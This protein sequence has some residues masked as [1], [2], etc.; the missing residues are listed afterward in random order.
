MAVTPFCIWTLTRLGTYSSRSFIELIEFVTTAKWSDVSP[1]SVCILAN[2]PAL[3]SP[4]CSSHSTNLTWSNL[5]AKCKIVAPL[6][7]NRK[8]SKWCGPTKKWQWQWKSC[9]FYTNQWCL[10]MRPLEACFLW[11]N[12]LFRCVLWQQRR[13]LYL[14]RP[15]IKQRY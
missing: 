13:A 5:L 6:K 1:L 2:L 15:K 10:W 11:S 8:K 12:R 14:R 4:L 9:F 3:L 7:R